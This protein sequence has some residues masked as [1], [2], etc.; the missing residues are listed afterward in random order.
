MNI[1]DQ[2]VDAAYDTGY[3]SGKGEDGTDLHNLAIRKCNA[4]KAEVL[5]IFRIKDAKIKTLLH[6]VNEMER[7]K[8]YP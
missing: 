5:A 6:R 3:Y 7:E 8:A 2:L 4:I 1:I